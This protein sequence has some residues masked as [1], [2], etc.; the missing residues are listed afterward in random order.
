MK[1]KMD[2]KNSFWLQLIR[3]SHQG[4]NIFYLFNLGKYLFSEIDENNDPNVNQLRDGTETWNQNFKRN[5][6][7]F[8]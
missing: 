8:F 7:K 6:S 1:Y 5:N 2:T 3:M 4:I